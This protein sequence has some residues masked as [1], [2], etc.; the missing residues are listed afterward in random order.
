MTSFYHVEVE[1]GRWV[2]TW[3]VVFYFRA[4]R[5]DRAGE[6]QRYLAE[7]FVFHPYFARVFYGDRDTT[8]STV[9]A[10]VRRRRSKFS[11]DCLNFY[12]IHAYV[13]IRLPILTAVFAMRGAN[14]KRAYQ[15][16]GLD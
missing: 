11:L 1:R 5:A 3:R 4:S 8:S 10:R 6:F 9:V 12:N 7:E 14:V 16:S 13:V 2:L 15:V